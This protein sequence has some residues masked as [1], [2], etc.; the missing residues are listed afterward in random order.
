MKTAR[1]IMTQEV[2][3][4]QPDTP[5]RELAQ[6][7][8]ARSISGV[9]V[10]DLDGKV[11][12]IATESDLIFHSKRLKVPTVLTILDSFIFLDS[13]EKMEKELRKIAAASVSDVY[14]SPPLTIN[15]DTPLDEIASL[16]T[17]KQVHTLPVLDETG[18]MIGI[19]GKKDIIRT[20]L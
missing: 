8:L 20:I 16:M 15:P 11:L 7:F 10:V 18:K 1:D 17:E 13:P 9:P 4:V 14:S 6:I 3:T 5:I 12:G 2:I 19:V